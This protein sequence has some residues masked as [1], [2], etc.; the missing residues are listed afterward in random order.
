MAIS[1]VQHVDLNINGSGTAF[2]ATINGV[3]VGNTLTWF[4]SNGSQVTTYQGLSDTLNSWTF[5][6][7]PP[8]VQNPPFVSDA[9]SGQTILAGYALKVTHGGNLTVTMSF[10]SSTSI[11]GTGSLAE[12][13][14]IDSET[15]GAALAN[16]AGAATVLTAL[17]IPA[18]G[19]FVGAAI[20]QFGS[21]MT[22]TAPLLSLDT[23][24][25]SG[26]AIGPASPYAA[27]WAN[28]SNR[29]WAAGGM[30]FAPPAAAPVTT[31]SGDQVTTSGGSPYPF[32]WEKWP[33]KREG[34]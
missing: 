15:A 30:V 4:V 3:T 13:S 14:G 32:V 16:N 7:G 9:T 21:G 22:P 6:S 27:T 8:N 20:Q 11:I 18:G 1:L 31:S 33:I 5:S 2:T 24:G 25:V 19:L 34:I 29:N 10:S 23:S 26:Y 12:F 28:A 17:T